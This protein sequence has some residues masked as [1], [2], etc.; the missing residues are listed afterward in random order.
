MGNLGIYAWVRRV[1]KQSLYVYWISLYF[2]KLKPFD[3]KPVQRKS[4]KTHHKENQ[5][6]NPCNG[7][8]PHQWRSHISYQCVFTQYKLEGVIP[9]GKPS[10]SWMQRWREE[11]VR[12]EISI[13][14]RS[15]VSAPTFGRFLKWVRSGTVTAVHRIRLAISMQHSPMYYSAHFQL[16]RLA[17]KGLAWTRM[18]LLSSL[19]SRIMRDVLFYSASLS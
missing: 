2:K 6:Y 4:G 9:L 15:L 17:R 7:Q 1:P 12:L 3:S 5:L 11:P 16:H 8:R 19:R 18:K 10:I 13:A 14:R